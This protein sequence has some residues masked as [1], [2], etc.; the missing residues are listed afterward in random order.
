NLSFIHYLRIFQD[1]FLHQRRIYIG[2]SYIWEMTEFKTFPQLLLEHA[3]GLIGVMLLA[4][5]LN[6]LLLATYFISDGWNG[7]ESVLLLISFLILFPVVYWVFIYRYTIGRV[8]LSVYLLL[9]KE[10]RVVFD[11]I[12]LEILTRYA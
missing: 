1:Y 12:T 6:F 3:R 10:L 9:Q 5:G 7:V 11:G 2:S 4:Y 8:L